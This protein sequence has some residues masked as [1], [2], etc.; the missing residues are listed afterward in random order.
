MR[1]D[2]VRDPKVCMIA[3][4]LLSHDSN[5]LR[6]ASVTR[7]V[8]RNAV[9]GALVTVW[10]VARQRGKRVG[11]DLRVVATKQI[12]DDISDLPGFGAAMESVGWLRED[13]KWL[14]FP[15]FFADY[16]V[17]PK[18]EGRAKGAERQRRY[19]DRKGAES[20]V[21]VTLRDV[22]VTSQ[23]DEREEKRREEKRKKDQDKAR[24]AEI[25]A[26][27][28]VEFPSDLDNTANREAWDRWLEHKKALRKSYKSKASQA[29]ALQ[30]YAKAG[31][32]GRR[33]VD[34]I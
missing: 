7:Y 11:D 24:R 33:F 34:G 29:V 23:S 3:T 27:T 16:N 6:N 5:A 15:N 22:T 12:V 20:D 18:E 30:S 13:A 26:N 9:V 1:T 21:T 17:D 14:Y 31:L 4:A 25:E 32:S 10:G 8:L 19:R 28:E 2:L